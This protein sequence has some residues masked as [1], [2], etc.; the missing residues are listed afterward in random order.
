MS[1]VFIAFL[2]SLTALLGFQMWAKSNIDTFRLQENFFTQDFDDQKKIFIL[3]SSEV[4]NLNATFINEAV[5]VYGFE[6]YNLGSPADTPIERLETIDRIISLKPELIV[7]GIGL[8]DFT[9]MSDMKLKIEKPVDILPQIQSIYQ[10]VDFYD[11]KLFESPKFLSLKIIDT[12]LY[13]FLGISSTEN[14]IKDRTPFYLHGLDVYKIKTHEE[15]ISEFNTRL[16]LQDMQSPTNNQNVIAFLKILEKFHKNNIDVIVFTT[17]KHQI[18]FDKLSSINKENF[19]KSIYI[20]SQTGVPLHRF[21]DKYSE[22]EIWYDYRHVAIDQA[23]II[24][25]KDVTDLIINYF[26]S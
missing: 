19:E 8:R 22:Q 1:V 24:F 17:P 16:L 6:I 3:G 12:I 15:V 2:I 11:F 18:Y 10:F 5:S 21:D 13:N 20:I 23:G 14:I 7:Y 9:E 4:A 26:N 25:S